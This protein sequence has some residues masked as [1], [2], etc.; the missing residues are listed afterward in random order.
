[1]RREGKSAAR[2]PVLYLICAFL[3]LVICVGYV[4][5]AVQLNNFSTGRILTIIAT[6]FCSTAFAWLWIVTRKTK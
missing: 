3:W 6:G 2:N 1:M 5:N 4:V